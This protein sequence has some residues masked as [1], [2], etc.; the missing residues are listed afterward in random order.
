MYL[1]SRI[2]VTMEALAASLASYNYKD[3]LA[4]H[5]KNNKG[6]WKD[7]LWTLT[8]FDAFEI[9]LGPFFSQLKESH[10]MAVAHAVV[11]IPKPGRGAYT[12]NLSLAFDG[13]GRTCIAQKGALG[14]QEHLGFLVLVGE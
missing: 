2:G 7:E 4:V 8:D 12:E 11:G 10:L 14:S 5:K 1:R 9:Q 3:F 13:R 6:L